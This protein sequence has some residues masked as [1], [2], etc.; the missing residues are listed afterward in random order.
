MGHWKVRH[1]DGWL[2]LNCPTMTAGDLSFR[3]KREVYKEL[4]EIDGTGKKWVAG[5][6][7]ENGHVM[8]MLHKMG[9]TPYLSTDLGVMF[10][11]ENCD[12]S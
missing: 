6:E 9:A 12:V 7:Y 8:K 1:V 5:T 2:Y 11:K 10:K 3:D 4:K